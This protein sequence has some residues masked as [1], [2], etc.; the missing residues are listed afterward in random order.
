[1]LYDNINLELYYQTTTGKKNIAVVEDTLSCIDIDS[2]KIQEEEAS[3]WYH[4]D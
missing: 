3:P 1:L 4:K 2:L